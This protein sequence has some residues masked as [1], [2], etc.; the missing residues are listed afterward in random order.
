MSRTFKTAVVLAVLSAVALGAA[1]ASAQ[2][3][4]GGRQGP[5]GRGFTYSVTRNG[6][7]A[8]GSLETNQGYGGTFSHSGGQTANGAYVGATTVNTNNG[9]TVTSHGYVND[10]LAAG[11]VTATGPD[12][13][14]VSRGGAVYIPR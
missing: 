6:G 4:S 12:G 2:T 11:T 9:T 1:D 14:T 5:N 13:Q 8:S 7:S 10:G 3:R